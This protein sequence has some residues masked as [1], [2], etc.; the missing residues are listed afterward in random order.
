MMQENMIIKIGSVY[1]MTGEF[2]N[3]EKYEAVFITAVRRDQNELKFRV[4]STLEEHMTS[5]KEF[6]K[7]FTSV[8][9]F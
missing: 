9:R 6:E 1:Q 3:L 8:D 5:A 2:K 7:H 4:V